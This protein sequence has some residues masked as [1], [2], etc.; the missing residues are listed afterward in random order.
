M[1]RKFLATVILVV[2]LEAQVEKFQVLANKVDT[3]NNIM[4][5]TGNVVIFSPSYYITAQKI[6]YDKNKG[7]FELFD[8][9]L[10]LKDNNVQTK[11]E[12]AFLDI[13]SDDLYQKPN[14][15]FEETEAIWIN[16]KDSE[17]KM[18]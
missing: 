13:N 7:T 1:L 11:S 16:S 5:A 6:I 18:M 10:I 12:Y 17:K 9:V 2:S 14:M 15:F 3:K 4:I 8:D